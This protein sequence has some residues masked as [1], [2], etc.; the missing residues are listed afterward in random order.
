MRAVVSMKWAILSGYCRSRTLSRAISR[1]VIVSSRFMLAQ[2]NQQTCRSSAAST[3]IRPTFPQIAGPEGLGT[4]V[5]E[6]EGGLFRVGTRVAFRSPGSWAELAA[7]PEGR[8][9]AVPDDITDMIGCQIA[10]N[11][12]TAW[13]LLEEC[14]AAPGD[15]ILL[16]AATS[17]V[18]NVVASIART[19][20][21]ETVGLV[22][23]D[24]S[25]K[26]SRSKAQRIISVDDSR[27]LESINDAA[28]GRRIAALLDSV[29]GATLTTLMGTL[30]PGAHILA[31]GV[32]DRQPAAITNAM[33]IYSNL[34]WKGFGQLTRVYKS[35]SAPEAADARLSATVYLAMVFR[36]IS[37]FDQALSLTQEAMGYFEKRG[38]TFLTAA[39]H[40]NQG[41][42]Y[43]DMQQFV[44][45]RSQFL[46]A[47]SEAHELGDEE[48]VAFAERG[49]CSVE[50]ELGQLND[51]R[52]TCNSASAV[53]EKNQDTDMLK[54][55]ASSLAEIE[56]L[57]GHAKRA[58]EILQQVFADNAAGVSDRDLAPLYL[59][60]ARLYEA[61]GDYRNASSDLSTYVQMQARLVD[62]QRNQQIAATHAKLEMDRANER[63]ESLTRELELSN[64]LRQQ[65]RQRMLWMTA[66][67][68]A[69]A[70]M[71]G[72]WLW[73]RKLASKA[74]AATAER[75]AA[76]LSELRY[77]LLSA[78]A[79]RAC[80]LAFATVFAVAVGH[81]DQPSTSGD[82]TDGAAII[83]NARKILAP[84]GV[85]RLQ[86]VRIG[87]ID[88]W[89]SIRGRDR[90]NPLLLV[91]HGGPGYVLMPES[92]WMSRDWEEYFTVV[93]WDQRGTGKT[94]LINDPEK[95][96]PTMTLA[97]SV[98]DAEEMVGWLRKEF[99][100][101]KIF[102][103]AHSAGT[104][105]GVQLALRHPDWLYA[106]LG[107]GQMADM[108]E[109]E[110]RGWAFAMDAAR[111]S[112]NAEAIHQLQSIAPYFAPGHPNPLKDLYLERKWVGYF[113]G[114]MAYRQD[115][116]ADSDLVKLSPDYTR[117]ELKHI[118]DGNEFAERFLLADLVDG[119]WSVTRRLACPLLLFE[120]RHDHTASSEV[121]WEW[122]EKVQA[123]AKRF[124][125]FENSGHMPMT[126]E[127][128]KFLVSLVRFA[129][130]IA[131][132]AGD[133]AP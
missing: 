130:P 15:C 60:R 65:Q 124:V 57:E 77:S 53:F 73:Y 122:F 27:M 33:M 83:A 9:I 120:G 101:Q 90:R 118:Y 31:Y 107:V 35:A 106:Y 4:V 26:A 5:R 63:S 2:S 112:G 30:A 52:R 89:V 102:V 75:L 127:P 68:I 29:G 7:V 49:L 80:W 82:L 56:R 131:E 128:G 125:W 69:G 84:N 43:A 12:L 95:L 123:S 59:Q 3:S 44:T 110:R 16:T 70:L 19:R 132:K 94:L 64:K 25:Q 54:R 86:T 88:Q 46:R 79:H 117:D 51:A 37:Q 92:W 126:E 104:Y 23:G 115:N 13:A 61:L 97:R 96:A 41:K 8:L 119:D 105:V 6:A 39:M 76:V 87:D 34:T 67:S 99:R 11:P 78:S 45:A 28:G 38:D 100:K 20:G 121:A 62:T 1:R 103:L 66:G 14:K 93:H 91:I 98:A 109:S 24:A 18:S 111:R 113:G 114:V 22:R 133:D 58:L 108:P 129:R 74:R 81:A 72:T 21:I 50:I 55:T 40:F 116:D 36:H 42:I 48:G 17:T 32:Q 85:E 47:E 71:I 10:L